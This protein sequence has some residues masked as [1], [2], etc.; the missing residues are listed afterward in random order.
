MRTTCLLTAFVLLAAGPA[1]AAP[2]I[3]KATSVAKQV[4]AEGS[5]S[6]RE[7]EARAPV[8]QNELVR[9]NQ[10]GVGQFEFLDRSRLAVGPNSAV[11]L[12]Q[13]VYQG[14]RSPSAAVLQL[15]RGAFRYISSRASHPP[16][17]V[18]PIATISVR[19][20]AFDLFVADNGALCVAMING[21]V[22]VCP[23]GRG[24]RAHNIVGRYL[25]I[26]PDGN[27]E[28]IDRWDGSLLGGATFA[29]A[30]PFLADQS[31]VSP[32]FR[33]PDSVAARYR[34]LVR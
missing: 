13:F 30:M 15:T 14:N 24:C 21:S 9:T 16:R 19:G 23:A 5:G 22:D 20:T 3:G 32:P 1:A 6:V 11:K 17:I 10:T 29:V 28:L 34:A 33:A 12:D 26:A 27:Y 31:R 25:I 2:E 7:L 8:L 4:T 18:T